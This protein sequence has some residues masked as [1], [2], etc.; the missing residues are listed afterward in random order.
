M[1]KKYLTAGLLL[2]LPLAITVWVLESVIRWSDVIVNLLPPAYRPDTLFGVS[3]PG[4]GLVIALVVILGTG[5]LVANYIGQAVLRLWEALLNRIP[6]VRPIY[7]GVK[8]ITSTIL[9]D[10]TDSFKEVVLVEF[11]Q[12][13]QWT[14]G[15]IVST[16]SQLIKDTVEADDLVTVYVPTAPNPTSGYVIMIS[17]KA[18]R[19]TEIS[20][21][22]AFKFHLSLGVMSPQV[23]LTQTKEPES[24]K[25][26]NKS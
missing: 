22:Q 3:I 19:K 8:Q 17:Q 18:I 2:W 7:S 12:K 26:A 6:L 4:F 13:N 11:P 20:V 16:P 9:S 24:G 10:N 5:V 1:L 14:L 21:D 23:D 15:F 25:S